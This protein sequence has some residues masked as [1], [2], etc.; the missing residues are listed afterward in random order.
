M[1]ATRRDDQKFLLQLP[2]KL[3]SI[4]NAVLSTDGVASAPPTFQIP[5][6]R[7]RGRPKKHDNETTVTIDSSDVSASTALDL[8]TTKS[9]D[10]C[11]LK[12]DR[13]W[14]GEYLD[15]CQF[16]WASLMFIRLIM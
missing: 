5:V 16:C 13:P 6:K 8:S 15:L 2:H 12:G 9:N 10:S 14:I 3:Q 1:S 7:K 4:M 11:D